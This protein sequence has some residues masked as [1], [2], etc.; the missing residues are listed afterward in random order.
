MI[1]N[2]QMS[3]AINK[4][5]PEYI[6]M[7]LEHRNDAVERAII[8]LYKVEKFSELDTS[9]GSYYALWILSGKKLSGRF[10]VSARNMT[11]KYIDQLSQ[12]VKDKHV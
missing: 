1:L 9:T 7:L 6:E 5:D 4:S 8:A 3:N 10:L 12:F 11:K 2:S